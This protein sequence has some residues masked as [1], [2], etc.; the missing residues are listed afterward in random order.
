M[1]SVVL[2]FQGL[3]ILVHLPVRICFPAFISIEKD[4]GVIYSNVLMNIM[5][6]IL[7]M[8]YTH[9]LL[10]CKRIFVSKVFILECPPFHVCTV[11]CILRNV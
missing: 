11:F 10:A 8:L 1:F 2:G 5:I 4:E 7:C 6:L 3:Y 9:S